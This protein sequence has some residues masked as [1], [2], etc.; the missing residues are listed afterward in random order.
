MTSQAWSGLLLLA[1]FGLAMSPPQAALVE[2]PIASSRYE[3]LQT[4]ALR[5]FRAV[6]NGDKPT[7]V[8]LTPAPAREGMT[9][10]LDEPTS[11]VARMLLTGSRAMRGRFM[12]IQTPRLTF[13]RQRDRDADNRV[14]VCFSDPRLEFK[15]PA[16]TADLAS[17]DSNRAEM[18]VPFVW[19]DRQWAVVL[20]GGR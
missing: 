8:R 16:T 19:T 2:V 15:T 18:C 5:F 20:G 4:E 13:L 6:R 11:P 1:V 3:S 9:K 17:T 10:D 14:T 7:L 12:S